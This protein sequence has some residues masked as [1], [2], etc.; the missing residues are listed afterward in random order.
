MKLS[1]TVRSRL[2]LVTAGTLGLYVSIS[3][4]SRGWLQALAALAVCAV[5]WQLSR[6][7]YTTEPVPLVIPSSWPTEEMIQAGC[8]SQYQPA[9]GQHLST[10]EEWVYNT[11]GGTVDRIRDML[12]AEFRAMAAA[13]P[14]AVHPAYDLKGQRYQDPE[15]DTY[16]EW[17]L[18][19]PLCLIVGFAW[20]IS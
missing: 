6:W 3:A 12:T 7:Y 14:G 8:I 9:P 4:L 1:N 17:L 18:A 11:S 10:Y 19:I 16:I 20:L 2:L 15:S 13:A 5:F